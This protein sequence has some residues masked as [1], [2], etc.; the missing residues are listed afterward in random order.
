MELIFEHKNSGLPKISIVLIDWSCR[1]SF[2]TLRYLNN[3]TV[4]RNEYEILWIEY[5]TRRSPEIEAALKECQ[6]AGKPPLVD[7]WIVMGMPEDVYYHKH[8]MYNAGIVAGRGD[9]I[10]FCDSDAIVQPT[11]V[12][13]I[14]KVFQEN[15]GIVLH[16]DEARNLSRRFYPFNYPAIEDVLGKGCVNW[17]DGKT[18]GLLDKR[19]P[20]HSRNYGACVS[21]L[22]KDLIRI[23][24]ADEHADYLGHICGPYEMTF[25]LINAGKKEIWHEK[26]F[27]YHTW[28]PGA[29]GFDNHSF[30]PHDGRNV[31]GTALDTRR[32]GR[33]MPLVE[34]TAIREMRLNRGG[35]SYAPLLS[36]IIPELEL[37]KWRLGR[38]EEGKK[39]KALFA[40]GQPVL[41][42]KIYQDILRMSLK[43]FFMKA[44]DY[45][46]NKVMQRNIFFELR[47]VFVFLWRMWR[48][49]IYTVAVCRQVISKLSEDGV[50]EI[51]C[52]GTGDITKI[53]SMLTEKTPIKISNIYDR[54]AAGKRFL[55][56]DV[57]APEGLVSYNRGKIVISSFVG[58]IEKAAELREIGVDEKNIVRLQ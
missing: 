41:K 52:Y 55:N 23:G 2:H 33:V 1:E 37:G 7:N 50:K 39:H 18:S 13:N 43:Q 53:L 12:E 4:P 57:L 28:H 22:K 17:K 29:D 44:R 38:A 27:L 19:D 40:A 3:Q 10:T 31:S 5:Y 6:K 58:I 8:L 46:G 47:L 35:I 16:I 48:N 20:I 34:N 49:N 42:Y 25:R 9:I 15:R 30:G 54:T 45:R 21:A 11:F 51:A 56:F 26:E 36:Q 24:G 32:S 14:I